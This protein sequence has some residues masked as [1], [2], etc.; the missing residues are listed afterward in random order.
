MLTTLFSNPIQPL[1][2][3]ASTPFTQKDASVL[4]EPYI[5]L[6]TFERTQT[7]AIAL[8][9]TTSVTLRS[10]IMLELHNP[11]IVEKSS[12]F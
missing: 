2:R 11:L 4:P 10:G 9:P 5:K 12:F 3:K 1:L 7:D 8:K 6:D